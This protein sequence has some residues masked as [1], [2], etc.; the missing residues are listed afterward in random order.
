V[1]DESPAG[2]ASY[3]ARFFFDPNGMEMGNYVQHSILCGYSGAS[4]ASHMLVVDFR[5][6]NGAYQV[7]ALTLTD[8]SGW[9]W[10]S[11]FPIS[12][13]EHY[14]EVE[15]QAASGE[16]ANDGQLALYIDG[17]ERS[18]L[19]ALDND[20]RRVERVALGAVTGIDG[21]THGSYYFDAFRSQ[22]ASYIG[23]AGV[24]ADFS[25]SPAGGA[26]PLTVQFSSLSEPEE[27]ISSY[28]WEF[29]DGET[30]PLRDPEHVYE[31]EGKYT[32]TLTVSGDGAQ[33]T[34]V[35]TGYIDVS[36]LIFADGFESTDLSAWSSSV[37]DGG[38]LSVSTDAALVGAY[39]MQAVIDDG[40]PVYV[41]DE[42][43]AGEA[44][45]RARFY[46]DPNGMEMGNYEMHSI[47]Y[48]YSGASGASHMLVVDFRMANGAYQ[49]RALTLTDESGWRWTTAP[50]QWKA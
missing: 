38:D 35:R 2:E 16:G 29:G 44:S 32:V 31:L 37:T 8:E 33:D 42:S 3:R 20:T 4:G 24:R 6:A 28:L 36:D 27:R 50:G 49:V 7:R 19:V 34:L 14:L 11:F 22:R 46:F 47:L 13:D 17:L 9:R 39:G 1:V 10:T 48:G 5:I 40:S 12:D 43:P 23:V 30:S 25:A 18:R 15:W 26:A 45:Y 41:V 21:G